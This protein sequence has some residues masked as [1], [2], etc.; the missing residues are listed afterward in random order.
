[1]SSTSLSKITVGVAGTAGTGSLGFSGFAL[2]RVVEAHGVSGG[3]WAAAAVL[4]LVSLLTGTLGM[5]LGYRI[6]RF[7]LESAQKLQMARLDMHRTVLEKAAGE[8]ASAESYRE[9]IIA[10]ALHLSVEQNGAHLADKTHQR[11]YGSG[12]ADKLSLGRGSFRPGHVTDSGSRNTSW[13]SAATGEAGRRSTK[14]VEHA[15]T[16]RRDGAGRRRRS[17]GPAWMTAPCPC[18]C[19]GFLPGRSPLL[20]RGNASTSTLARLNLSSYT[21]PRCRS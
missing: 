15:Q 12:P 8:P 16:V 20:C 13:L 4:A 3:V 11:L 1:M 18:P 2:A 19:P 7:E 14:G 17:R 5:V 21:R 10:D 9:L 6:R